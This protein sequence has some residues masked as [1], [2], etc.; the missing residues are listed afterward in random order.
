MEIIFEKSVY[1]WFLLVVPIIII[2]HFSTLKATSK[3]AIRF[4]NFQAIQRI[5]G[6]Q[7]LSKN[8]FLLTIRIIII[9]D[10]IFH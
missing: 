10:C 5:T 4:A 9:L 1:L 8:F 7:P 6:A 2:V 3:K